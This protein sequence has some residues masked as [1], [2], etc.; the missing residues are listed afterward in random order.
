MITRSKTKLSSNID[1]EISLG[2]GSLGSNNSAPV[3]QRRLT[4]AHREYKLAQEVFNLARLCSDIALSALNVAQQQAKEAK[5][6][7]N[8]ARKGLFRLKREQRS[9]DNFSWVFGIREEVKQTDADYESPVG[10]IFT[11]AWSRYQEREQERARDWVLIY[12]L[13]A[14]NRSMSEEDDNEDSA[15]MVESNLGGTLRDIPLIAEDQTQSLPMTSDLG[16]PETRRLPATAFAAVTDR[17]TTTTDFGSR[18]I[19][20]VTPV[21]DTRNAIARRTH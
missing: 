16:D 12:V 13:A 6:A 20:C 18:A 8:A 7:A 3:L 15:S 17:S 14:E 21:P 1:R 11:R 4:Y 9:A 5:S 10:G 19:A 2:L